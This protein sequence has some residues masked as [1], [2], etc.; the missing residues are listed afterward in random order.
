MVTLFFLKGFCIFIYIA[1]SLAIVRNKKWGMSAKTGSI[2]HIFFANTN[3]IKRSTTSMRLAHPC[4][5]CSQERPCD[6]VWSAG[7]ERQRS[8]HFWADTFDYWSKTLHRSHLPHWLRRPFGP[9]GEVAEW[10]HL[11]LK[12][13]WVTTRRTAASEAA[14][15]CSGYCMN[16]KSTLVVSSHWSLSIAYS[17]SIPWPG[18]TNS[19]IKLK[20]FKSN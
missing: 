2:C 13:H 6:K 14:Q 9:D 17:K 3:K 16:A 7:G 11:C 8:R 15:T 5:P 19:I 12:D 20:F 1:N 18:L 10:L 4:F